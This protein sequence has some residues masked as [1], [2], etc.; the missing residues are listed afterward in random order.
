[1][2][3][4]KRIDVP[5]IGFLFWSQS[6]EYFCSKP[7]KTYSTIILAVAITSN[8]GWTNKVAGHHPSLLPAPWRARRLIM[9][10]TPYLT[11]RKAFQNTRC[12][13]LAR[14]HFPLSQRGRGGGKLILNEIR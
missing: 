5:I 14:P 4:L 7:P 10:F 8:R 1:M 11:V 3:G 2:V 13:L 6:E 9:V 12:F